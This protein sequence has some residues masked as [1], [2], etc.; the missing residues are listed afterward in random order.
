VADDFL[1]VFTGFIKKTTNMI[2]TQTFVLPD[3]LFSENLTNIGYAQYVN[4]AYGSTSGFEVTMQK[5]ITNYFTT[6]F[7]YTYM[8]ANGTNPAGDESMEN[9]SPSQQ[10][11]TEQIEFPLSW[12]QRHTFVVDAGFNSSKLDFNVLYRLFSPLPFTSAESETPNDQRLSWRNLLDIRLKLKST[13]L[14]KGSLQPFLEI[15]NIFND[16]N[17]I[18]QFDNEGVEAYRL[19][20]PIRADHGRR[21]RLG[22]SLDF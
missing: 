8:K 7:S 18:N 10:K 21:L 4:S 9:A 15:R 13:K 5:R 6:R 17:E 19:F 3:S 2:D 22:V 20:S 14:L 1:F 11:N 12:D 16:D